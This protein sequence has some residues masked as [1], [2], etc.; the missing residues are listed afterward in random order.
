MRRVIAAVLAAGAVVLAG[1]GPAMAAPLQ[2]EI[3][4][5]E[6]VRMSDHSAIT[7]SFTE[8]PIHALQSL[9]F[10]FEPTGG[11]DGR[12]GLV[13]IVSPSGDRQ[14]LK[15]IVLQRR[16][17]SI[18]LPRHPRAPQVWG[19]DVVSLP[20]E[21]TWQFEFAVE[22]P[23]GISTGVLPIR[24]IEQPGPPLALSWTVALTP[25]APVALLVAM[26][27]RRTR[28]LRRSATHTWSG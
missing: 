19:L 7:V 16:G 27:W 17:D 11:I 22:G 20:E 12:A 26:G 5:S 3:V 4:H 23:G 28:R 9:D 8:W 21:G 2:G 24:T 13:T 15:G 14:G 25:W 18:V 6:V 10:T 1:A